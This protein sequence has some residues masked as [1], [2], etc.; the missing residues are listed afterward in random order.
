MTIT[1]HFFPCKQ[2]YEAFGYSVNFAYDENAIL[3]VVNTTENEFS[4]ERVGDPHAAICFKSNLSLISLYII[5]SI[6]SYNTAVFHEISIKNFPNENNVTIYSF[7]GDAETIS[8][9]QKTYA[10]E[11]APASKPTSQREIVSDSPLLKCL[12]E[13]DNLY[14]CSEKYKIVNDLSRFLKPIAIKWRWRGEA[15][16][17]TLACSDFRLENNLLVPVETEETLD[18]D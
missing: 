8:I 14:K 15:D 1:K 11:K 12:L 6:V 18:N 3:F 16:P 17:E 4:V 2:F 13:C 7:Y 10:S 9:R 5:K